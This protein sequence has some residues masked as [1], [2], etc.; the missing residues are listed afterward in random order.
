MTWRLRS[1]PSTV[2]V[3][4]AVAGLLGLVAAGAIPARAQGAG[5]S[6]E[7]ELPALA[8]EAA[9]QGGK[10]RKIGMLDVTRMPEAFGG[11]ATRPF[12]MRLPEVSDP[13]TLKAMWSVFFRTSQ[14]FIGVGAEQRPMIGFYSPLLDFWLLSEW[15]A[16]DERP[17]LH[18]TTL[19]PGDAGF[20]GRRTGDEKREDRPTWLKLGRVIAWPDALQTQTARAVTPFLTTYSPAGP[21]ALGLPSEAEGVRA[22]FRNRAAGFVLGLSDL[23]ADEQVLSLYSSTLTAL[24][25]G[26]RAILGE[27]AVGTETDAQVS[28]LLDLPQDVRENMAPALAV[29]SDES[30]VIIANRPDQARLFLITEYGVRNGYF[31]LTNALLLDAYADAEPQ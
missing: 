13:G 12:D 7:V 21:H 8:I 17:R 24:K 22:D 23:R 28:G 19:L 9:A 30:V 1:V 10:L 4:V 6:K 5:P 31:G 29:V 26:D 14:I 20:D 3:L 2:R 11:D 25:D 15:V 16:G 18:G 27:I